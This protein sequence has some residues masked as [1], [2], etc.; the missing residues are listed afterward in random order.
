MPR[1]GGRAPAATP[2]YDLRTGRPDLSAFPRAAWQAALGRALRTIPDAGLDYGDP[3]GAPALRAALASHLGRTRGVA[4]GPRDVVVT[5]G[6]TQGLALVWA[7]LRERG[8]RRVAVEDPGWR[9]QRRTVLDAGLEAV[10]VPVDADGLDVD[11]LLALDPPVDAVALTPAHQFPTGV[12]LAPARRAALVRWA[13]ETGGVLVED[14]YDADHRYDREP[15]GALQALAPAHVVHAGSA[16]KAL[17]PALRL[18]WLVL[19]AGLVAG[20]AGQRERAT[21]AARSWAS[22]RWPTSS[23]AAPSPA[24]CG[25]RAVTTATAATPSSPRS[26]RACPPSAWAAWRRACTSSRGCRTGSTR[27]GWRAPPRTAAWRSTRCTPIARWSPR[28]PARCSSATPGCP[29][30]RCAGPSR[31]SPRRRRTAVLRAAARHN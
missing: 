8:A 7:A 30:R 6:V 16:S 31:C 28:G 22:S 3:R 29:S 4:A 11:A 14:D 9:S 26:G 15:V 12:V 1:G 21:T 10:P 17:A 5:T 24:T 27:P 25:G 23:T 2:A 18:G 19:P 13:A 20:V